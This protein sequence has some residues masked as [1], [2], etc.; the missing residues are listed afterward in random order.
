[1]T[2]QQAFYDAANQPK[3]EALARIREE[4]G[5]EPRQPDEFTKADVAEMLGITYKGAEY[6][7]DKLERDGKVTSRLLKSNLRLYR[8]V[9]SGE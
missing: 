2:E 5:D 1:M 3:R 9:E 8:W 7:L 4:L 6:R